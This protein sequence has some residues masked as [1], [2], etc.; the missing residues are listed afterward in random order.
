M[1]IFLDSQHN[2]TIRLW[3]AF[4]CAKQ[5]RK[6]VLKA[7]LIVRGTNLAYLVFACL[8]AKTNVLN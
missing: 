2:K 5:T 8:F 3:R 6:K 1:K 4:C 7:H